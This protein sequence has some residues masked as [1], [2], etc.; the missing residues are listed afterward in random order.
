MTV[1]RTQIEGHNLFSAID[2]PSAKG[3]RPRGKIVDNH[4]LKASQHRIRLNK[5]VREGCERVEDVQRR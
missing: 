3:F 4:W 5:P 1:P 2:F